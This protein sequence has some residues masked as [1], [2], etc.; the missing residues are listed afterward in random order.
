MFLNCMTCFTWFFFFLLKNIKIRLKSI[1][2]G[3]RSAN[4]THR[5]MPNYE[6]L[7]KVDAKSIILLILTCF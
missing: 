6:K 1:V 4:L 2:K 7:I 5:K 3:P